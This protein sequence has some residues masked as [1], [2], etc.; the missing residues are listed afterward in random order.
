M[1]KIEAELT[2]IEQ[3]VLVALIVKKEI[4]NA[5]KPEIARMYRNLTAKIL[6]AHKPDETTEDL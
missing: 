1:V 5:H 2:D 6:N 3:L 4:E